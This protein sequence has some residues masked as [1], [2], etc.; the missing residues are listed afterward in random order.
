MNEFKV[1]E[2]ITLKLEG[3]QTVIYVDGRKFIQCKKLVL[4]IPSN[5]AHLY[6]GMI[7]IDDASEAYDYL[8]DNGILEE[9]GSEFSKTELVTEFSPENEFW[10]HCSNLQAWYEHGY[11]TRL[12]KSNLSFPLLKKLVGAGDNLARKFFKEEVAQRLM[13]RN[14]NVILFILNQ[15]YL[16]EFLKE[17]KDAILDDFREHLNL[18]I[19]DILLDD[20]KLKYVD[21]KYV[22]W[23]NEKVW[24]SNSNGLY[25][26]KLISI[27]KGNNEQEFEEILKES[28]VDY[29]YSK[30]DDYYNLLY[31]A[32]ADFLIYLIDLQVNHHTLIVDTNYGEEVD[33]VRTAEEYFHSFRDINPLRLNE[34]LVKVLPGLDD[35]IIRFMFRKDF[36]KNLSYNDIK[37][38]LNDSDFGLSSYFVE[39][40]KEIFFICENPY[41]DKE[42]IIPCLNIS[43]N[44]LYNKDLECVSLF[45]KNRSIKKISQVNGLERLTKLKILDLSNNEISEIEGLEN[46]EMLELLSLSNNKIERMKGISSL[47][48]LKNIDLSENRI[49]KIEQLSQLQN[50]YTLDLSGNNILK[51]SGLENCPNLETLNLNNNLI[52]EIEGLDSCK[53]LTEFDL[54]NNNISKIQGLQNLNELEDVYLRNNNISD[55]SGIKTAPPKLR[56]ME[57]EGNPLP[58]HVIESARYN[59]KEFRKSLS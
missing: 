16:E 35:R 46:L 43:A 24:S 17:E 18:L 26:H 39:Y 42:Y 19:K 50:L 51:I 55:I 9:M 5:Q 45:I 4:N 34:L 22:K 58:R 3:N 49:S 30:K 11:D 6:D 10:G 12:L 38:F 8:H 31:N 57:L 27:I 48:N 44:R 33:L 23:F 15:N 59:F 54:T 7:S 29:F 56:F 13:S 21:F 25:L 47:K 14:L 32:S 36:F 37:H 20:K 52:S 40:E 2:Y 1:N 28:V 53:N 41:C